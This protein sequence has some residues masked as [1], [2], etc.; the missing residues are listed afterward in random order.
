MKRRG[1]PPVTRAR[2]LTYWRKHAPCSVMQ[3]VRATG[4]DRSTVKRIL[5]REKARIDYGD[6]QVKITQKIAARFAAKVDKTAGHGPRGDCW[7]WTGSLD[8]AGYAQGLYVDGRNVRGTHLAMAIDGRPRP[9]PSLLALHSCDYRPC[10]NPAHL[11]W[12]TDA[13]NLED[14]RQ[15]GKRGP[16]WLPD[17]IVHE[18]HQSSE[19]NFEIAKR[20]GLSQAAI[21]II[22]TGRSHRRI[23]EY[24][25][26][27]MQASCLA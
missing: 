19:R 27:I 3:V 7:L 8:H 2:I 11:R 24:Y 9:D 1:R 10:V 21:C 17:E 14:H 23:Y 22:R 20:L 25:H 13:E 5:L 6:D 4:S 16:H 18:I 12:G 26:P 15:R